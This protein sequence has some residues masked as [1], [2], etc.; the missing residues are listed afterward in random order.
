MY[1]T[2]T[3]AVPVAGLNVRVATGTEDDTL[4]VGDVK[5][6]RDVVGSDGG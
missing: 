2:G 4:G 5:T 6:G 3:P 1:V